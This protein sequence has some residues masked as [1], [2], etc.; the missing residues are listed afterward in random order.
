MLAHSMCYLVAFV[1]GHFEDI[2]D[3]ALTNVSL[4]YSTDHKQLQTF[5]RPSNLREQIGLVRPCH[6]NYSALWI[7]FIVKGNVE[8][9][10]AQVGCRS[11]WT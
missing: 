10:I 5:E 8:R 11:L 2:F 3:S 6:C 7:C 1:I 4:N 9:E